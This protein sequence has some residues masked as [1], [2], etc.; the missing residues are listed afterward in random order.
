MIIEAL[1]YL[2]RRKKKVAP[3]WRGLGLNPSLHSL[4]SEPSITIIIPTRDRVELL[5]NCIESITSRTRY[6]NYKIQVI[7]NDSKEFRTA[8]YLEELVKS[9]VEVLSS[10]GDFNYSKI[11]NYGIRHTET[12][13]I[14]LL[15]NDTVITQG[16]WLSNMTSH[17]QDPNVGIVGAIL[18]FPNS[19]IQHAG[20]AI[21]L[22]GLAG[23]VYVNTQSEKMPQSA[24]FEVSAV[25]FACALFRKATWTKI[26]GLNEKYKVGLNDVDFCFR[27]NRIGLKSVVCK[28]T[29]LIHFESQ[30]RPKMLSIKGAKRASAEIL[31]FSREYR[32]AIENDF[33]FEFV[34]DKPE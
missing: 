26:G 34:T 14:C 31:H 7:D 10:P 2:Q 6:S 11:I 22:G 5:R 33:Y 30:S 27:S 32:N 12:D 15:N 8:S 29:E 17:L 25:T 18:K 28:N 3:L 16:D 9:G 23:H 20:I 24:C 19:L 1:R 4:P 21:G 13:L